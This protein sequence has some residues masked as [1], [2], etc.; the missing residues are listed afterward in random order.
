MKLLKVS[1]DGLNMFKDGLSLDF[2]ATD[3]G[4]INEA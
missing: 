4:S 3:R 1:F 2:F